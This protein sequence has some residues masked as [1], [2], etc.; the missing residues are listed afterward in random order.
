MSDATAPPG[1]T[2][3]SYFDN[4]LRASLLGITF[5]FIGGLSTILEISLG[6]LYVETSFIGFA[7]GD[8]A[9]PVSI[10]FWPFVWA[11]VIGQMLF[12]A[13]LIWMR[14]KASLS[15]DTWYKV[16][17]RSALVCV[18]LT[19]LAVVW[20]TFASDSLAWVYIP[21]QIILLAGSDQAFLEG[22]TRQMETDVH[23]FTT[24]GLL[25]ATVSNIVGMALLR[26][27]LNFVM[28]SSEDNGESGS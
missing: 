3:S 28:L 9:G 1:D 8:Q 27:W 2:Q 18:V 13:G 26:R 4:A 16:C 24:L 5:F 11:A 20:V 25:I 15:L 21:E 22:I 23:V 17:Q 6:N 19:G 7:S 14:W 10:Y 12:V